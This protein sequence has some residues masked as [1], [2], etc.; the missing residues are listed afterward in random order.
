VPGI[1][2][3]YQID[4]ARYGLPKDWDTIGLVINKQAAADAGVDD[5]T[6][7]DL[8]WN[9]GDGGTFEEVIAKLTVDKAGKRGDEPGFDKGN[10][11]VYGFLPEWADGSQGQNLWGNLAQSN[12]FTYADKN[13][14]GT[15]FHYDD[16]KLAETIEWMA[17]LADKGYAPPFDQQST[18][19]RLEVLQAGTGAMTSMGSFNQLM[20]KDAAADYTFAPLPTGPEGRKSAI[21]GLSDAMYAGGK[22]KDQAWEWI[23]YLASADCQTV[24]GDTGVVFPANKEASDASVAARAELGLDASVFL[25]Y[26]EDPNGT[27]LIP[28]TYNGAEMSQIVQDAIQSVALGTNDAET[29]LADAN[30]KVNALFK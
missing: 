9:P 17:S 3:I 11:A 28:I 27:F 29:A 12:G 30:A 26:S 5:A 10:V 6:L 18:L 21:N 7:Q 19:S 22:H 24:V 16:P 23:K 13:P 1:A 25:S 4:D 14:F 8:T 15:S 20:F 2:E